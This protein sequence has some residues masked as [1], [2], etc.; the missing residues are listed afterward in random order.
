[1]KKVFI[2][3]PWIA[4]MPFVRAGPARSKKNIVTNPRLSLAGQENSTS[5]VTFF[6]T[7]AMYLLC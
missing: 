5:G 7:F 3:N 2:L 1:M 6:F 4:M